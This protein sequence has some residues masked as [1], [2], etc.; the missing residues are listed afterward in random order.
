[1]HYKYST[2]KPNSKIK[3]PHNTSPAE[4]GNLQ[5]R[6]CNLQVNDKEETGRFLQAAKKPLPQHKLTQD[7]AGSGK[8]RREL[9]TATEN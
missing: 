9:R 6:I 5:F 3:N 2:K 4:Y 7:G 1:L 8:F